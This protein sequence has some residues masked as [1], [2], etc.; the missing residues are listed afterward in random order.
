MAISFQQAA[1]MSLESIQIGFMPPADKVSAENLLQLVS[2]A[3]S[4]GFDYIVSPINSPAY[5]R[6]LFEGEEPQS[7]SLR[8]WRAGLESFKPEDLVLR[9]ADHSDFIV[10]T[11]SD[12][13]DFDSQDLKVRLHS[14]LAL[15]QQFNWASHLALGGVMLPYP[16]SSKPLSN[17]GR[18]L[19]SSISMLPYTACWLRVPCMDDDLERNVAEEL[20]GM[21]SWERWNTILNMAG[22]QSKLGIALELSATLPTDKV[23]DRWFAEPIK[24]VIIPED[25]FLTNNKGYPVL[26]KRHQHVVRKFMR[27]KPYFMIS[28]SSLPRLTLD[29]F[30]D[31]LLENSLASP[32]ADYLRYLYRTQDTL[33]VIDQF[34]TGYQDYLQAPLQP[35]QDNLESSTYETFEKD[36]IKYQQYE[37]AVERALL[38]R[39]VPTDG[40]PDVTVIMVVGAGRG[41]LVNCSLRAAEKAGRNVRIYAVEK[42]PNAFVTIQNMKASL[43][44]DRVNIVFSDMRTWNPPEQADILVSE[45]LGSFG[46]NELSP[47]C[48]DGAQKVLKPDGISIPANY[49]AFVAPMSSNKL[50]ADVSSFKDLTHFE[51][52][53]VVMFKAISLLAQPKPIWVFEHPNRKDIPLDQ[54]PLSNHHN[55]RSGSIEFTS[56]TSGMIHGV[57]GYFES[58]LYK[59]V[60]LSINPETHSPGMFS[61]FPIYFPIKTPL[62][63]PAGGQVVLD[64]WRL[65][66]TRKVWY[67]WQV[68]CKVEGLGVIHSSSLHNVGG[69]SSSIGLY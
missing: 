64:F 36:P 24:V 31:D 51:T 30:S 41:P 43:W 17:Y 62:Y 52:S 16:S 29:E 57:A 15:K 37:L 59:D 25:I 19:T 65:T 40:T 42:N 48:L 7:S 54:N 28:S 58:V 47:E 50:H 56:K 8:A 10:G 26:S 1:A 4:K 23:L 34:A 32:H 69:R 33:G 38:D 61:W 46:D 44:G 20:Q 27:F 53:Y 66:D 21:K 11:I 63:I 22:P 6:V 39:P 68:S 18:V 5:R 35:L 49:T 3:Q 2:Y 45:L 67:E 60:L 9:T 12:W 14:E 13:Q 55:I